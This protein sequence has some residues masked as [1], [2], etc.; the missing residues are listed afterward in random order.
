MSSK[1]TDMTWIEFT[2][3]LCGVAGVALL[4]SF[5]WKFAVGLGLLKFG[6]ALSEYKPKP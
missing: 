4:L 6:N 3:F 5:D 1:T 2:A